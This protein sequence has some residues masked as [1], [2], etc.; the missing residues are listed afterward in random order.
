MPPCRPAL[1]AMLTVAAGAGVQTR[2]WPWWAHGSLA[3]LTL[4]V[5][6]WAFAV[7]YRN[8]A[9]S[10]GVIDRVLR[11][12]DRIRAERGLPP[13]AGAGR[14]GLQ[15]GANK[16]LPKTIQEWV[17][18]WQSDFPKARPRY[19]HVHRSLPHRLRAPPGD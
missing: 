2:A 14:T 11:E 12:V 10:A 6:A 7:E 13:N 3:L 8:V 18:Y 19:T 17:Q 5:N 1:F 15:L 4:A 9:V 16:S